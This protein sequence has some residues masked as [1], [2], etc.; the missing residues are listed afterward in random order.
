MK[1]IPN[2]VYQKIYKSKLSKNEMILMLYLCRCCNANGMISVAIRALAQELDLPLST[3]YHNLDS[4]CEKELIIMQK[5]RYHGE[6]KIEIIGC[7]YIKNDKNYNTVPLDRECFALPILKKLNTAAIRVH[8]YT[9][10]RALKAQGQDNN[11]KM[12]Y[13]NNNSKMGYDT[14]RRSMNKI[15]SLRSIQRGF[16]QLKDNGII[17]IGIRQINIGDRLYDVFSV[18]KSLL[19]EIKVEIT[20]KAKNIKKTV[21]YFFEH[22]RLEVGN[23]CRRLNL[24]ISDRAKNDVAVLME[25][26]K[27]RAE[28]IGMKIDNVLSAALLTLSKNNER[29]AVEL[30]DLPSLNI[31]L[32]NIISAER[33]TRRFIR[34]DEPEPQY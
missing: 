12:Y 6:K 28:K 2:E 32:T 17:N 13:R 27:P 10:F 14:I 4:L 3:T 22:Y 31:I 25:Q 9:V 23:V 20:E 8:L 26:F 16:K 33:L 1:A 18:K 15:L 19:N 7:E 5:S 29:N 24:I 30:S 11:N 34:F 21:T